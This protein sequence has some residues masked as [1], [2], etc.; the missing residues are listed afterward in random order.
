MDL[1]FVIP[2]YMD[3]KI[4]TFIYEESKDYFL[5]RG[6]S[7]FLSFSSNIDHIKYLKKMGFKEVSE[8]GSTYF[9]KSIR[10]L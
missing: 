9:V 10:D 5:E 8:N 1:D 4:G 7:R 2:D 3:F 6:Y